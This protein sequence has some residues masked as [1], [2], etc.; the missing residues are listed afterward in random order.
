MSI[1]NAQY[2]EILDSAELIRK[3]ILEKNID[4]ISFGGTMPE[5]DSNEIAA[6]VNIEKAVFDY[7]IQEGLTFSEIK[8]RPNLLETTFEGTRYICQKN[9][10][11]IETIVSPVVANSTIDPIK[12]VDMEDDLIT[13]SQ[14]EEIFTIEYVGSCTED[15][16]IKL[17]DLIITSNL[18]DS[19]NDLETLTIK[20]N[21]TPNNIVRL[22]EN[23]IT[24]YNNGSFVADYHFEGIAK[25]EPVKQN[26]ATYIGSDI[27]DYSMETMPPEETK[28][29]ATD[30]V[31]E[32]FKIT[33]NHPGY[34]V[35][36]AEYELIIAP[37]KL[38]KR[39]VS[40]VPIIATITKTGYHRIT[41]SSYD[42]YE[43]GKNL[44]TLEIDDFEILVR[45]TFDANGRYNTI[46]T[47]TGKSAQQNDTLTVV[48][49]ESFGLESTNRSVNGHPVVYYP[50][51]E[52]HAFI[53]VLPLGSHTEDYF[54]VASH[55]D[56]FCEY[57][58]SSSD[59]YGANRAFVYTPTG[60]V[61][62]IPTWNNGYLE[63]ETLEV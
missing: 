27:V 51:D 48:S 16:E 53:F 28:T 22:G 56:E 43:D 4:Y 9:H 32:K 7:L 44:V 55:T 19:V 60:E 38:Y 26:K 39:A 21:D 62:I 20:Y 49:K 17:E 15:D 34:N 3:S 46:I 2:K 30:L 40:T 54:L 5:R 23:I 12:D 41:K 59:M 11:P 35:D 8:D 63:I 58:V 42:S 18:R 25:P 36:A 45:G 31:Y 24:L 33:L 14:I 10:T 1:F 29:A 61:T 57:M 37:L 6:V 52:G 13:D 47:T 50:S